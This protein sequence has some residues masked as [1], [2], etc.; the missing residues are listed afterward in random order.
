MRVVALIVL[1]LLAATGGGAASLDDYSAMVTGKGVLELAETRQLTFG[2]DG[3]VVY[4]EISPDGRY[5]AYCIGLVEDK[6]EIGLVSTSGGK[7]VKILA[8]DPAYNTVDLA[9]FPRDREVWSVG[10]EAVWS[11]N[12]KLVAFPASRL[13]P[14]GDS[15]GDYPY[16]IVATNR[17]ARRA[18]IPMDAPL[19]RAPQFSPDSARLLG[20]SDSGSSV[21]VMVFDVERATCRVVY[22]AQGESAGSARWAPDGRSVLLTVDRESEG[23]ASYLRIGLDGRSEEIGDWEDTRVGFV[24]PDGRFEIVSHGKGLA[25]KETPTGKLRPLTTGEKSRLLAWVDSRV[26]VYKQELA[27]AADEN[28]RSRSLDLL[29][30]GDVESPKLN[31]MLVAADYLVNVEPTWSRDGLRIAYVAQGTVHVAVLSRRDATPREKL[32]AGLPLSREEEL[33]VMMENAKAIGNAMHM[34]AADWDDNLPTADYIQ[35]I[36]E[37]HGRELGATAEEAL[38]PYLGGLSNRDA[39]LRPGTQ[40]MIFRFIDPGPSRLTDLDAPSETVIG[41]LDAGDGVVIQIF[42]DG[43]VKMKRP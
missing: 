38:R 10:A 43:H 19:D 5:V 8:T 17:G 16:L 33:Q 23:A 30:L 3:E 20:M 1:P 22:S 35:R 21:R 37:E 26:F 11:P 42:T 24:S 31:T 29:W 12:S 32:K 4:A 41:E 6:G 25:I 39:F 7:A 34:F 2:P 14:M 9:T 18:A 27:I 40:N 15:L 36:R 13:A 28:G